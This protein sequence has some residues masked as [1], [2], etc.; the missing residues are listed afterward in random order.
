MTC[1]NSIFARKGILRIM[2]RLLLHLFISLFLPGNFLFA[3]LPEFKNVLPGETLAQNCITCIHQDKSGHM[4]FGTKYGLLKYDGYTFTVYK[5]NP[6]DNYSITGNFI[7]SIYEGKDGKLWIATDDGGL[8]LFDPQKEAFIFIETDIQKNPG[9]AGT[10]VW[11]V[12][13]DSKGYIWAGHAGAG[14]S[15]LEPSTG[16]IKQYLH[17]QQNQNSLS[18]NN[19]KSIWI[20][21]DDILWIGTEKGGLNRYDPETENFTH[22]K[23]EAGNK[24]SLQGNNIWKVFEDHKQ[25]LWIATHLTG[26]YK[27]DKK[28]ENFISYQQTLK[29]SGSSKHNNIMCVYEDSQ[30]RMWA[31]GWHD[32]LYILNDSNDKVLNFQVNDENKEAISVTAIGSD[33]S[34]LIWVGTEYK[35]LFVHNPFE[36]KFELLNDAGIND[37]SLPTNHTHA[38]IE[39]KAGDVIIGTF[40]ANLNQL[41]IKSKE[42][43]DLAQNS[44]F[45]EKVNITALTR[46][47]NNDLWIGTNQGVFYQNSSSGLTAHYKNDPNDPG[48]LSNNYISCILMDSKKNIWAGTLRHGLNIID[49]NTNEIKHFRHNENDPSSLSSDNIRCL[50]MISDSSL[51]I[52]TLRGG[53]NKFDYSSSGFIYY[54]HNAENPNS[55]SNNSVWDIYEDKCGLLWLGTNGGGLNSFDPVKSNFNYYTKNEGLASDVICAITS[56]NNGNLWMSTPK[57][58]SKFNVF[59]NTFFNY[60]EN[61]GLQNQE[62]IP[63]AVLNTTDGFIYFG[64]YGGLNYFH[65]DSLNVKQTNAPVHISSIKNFQEE[66]QIHNNKVTIEADNNMLSIGFTA[67]NFINPEKS[68]YACQLSGFDSVWVYMGTR[69][70]IKYNMLPSG[71]Y[72]F[73]V[74]A[75]TNNDIWNEADTSLLIEVKKP[76]SK[77]SLFYISLLLFVF[78]ISSLSYFYLKKVKKDKSKQNRYKGSTLKEDIAKQ[79]KLKL[80]ELM[81]N[82]KPFLEFSLNLNSCAQILEMSPHHLSQI[83]N[84]FYNK[85]FSEYINEFRIEEAKK[86]IRDTDLKIEAIAFESGFNSPTA[87]YTAFKKFTNQTPTQ[88]RKGN[89]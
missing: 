86:L 73:K 81:I 7:R 57:G 75:A 88:F 12:A 70:Q 48:S 25:Q 51:W 71:I 76:Y 64:G 72:E 56:D 27:F 43:R 68:Q 14:L 9:P 19:I 78:L 5:T 1:R 13:G 20:D 60:D 21:A 44:I 89:S 69:R 6:S 35:G 23:K 63:G 10:F 22:Y 50:E 24:L 4:W 49:P 37:F 30:K 16:K 36:E 29:R 83:I 87:F 32:G 18:D 33:R 79:Q 40:G 26:L 54:K 55:I 58:V 34:G 8:N 77:S 65:P 82:S 47:H 15:R 3:Q 52:G 28:T 62:F 67:I 2:K 46:D 61:D 59:N 11:A 31:G 39:G 53:L 42:V 66:I 41:N 45:S 80:D 84:Q 38:L 17:N 85:S 74:K